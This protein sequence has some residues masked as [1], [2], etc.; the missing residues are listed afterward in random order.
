MIILGFSLGEERSLRRK[1][2]IREEY[3]SLHAHREVTRE[4]GRQSS[5]VNSRK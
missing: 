1:D 2:D 5:H 4:S 3:S